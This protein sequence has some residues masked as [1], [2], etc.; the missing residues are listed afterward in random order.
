MLS[1]RPELR[2]QIDGVAIHPYAPTPDDVLH[3]VVTA[4]QAMNGLGL[5]K[6]PLYVTEIGWSTSPS[7]AGKYAPARLRP[8]YLETLF[9]T[10]GHTNCGIAATILY[11]WMTPERNPA[12]GNDWLGIHP[13]AGGDTPDVRAFTNGVRAARSPR[14]AV[15]ICG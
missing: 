13:P 2:G 7:A 14:R 4:R 3:G 11:A 1:A 12:E 8:G 10:L 6:V 5:A 9:T 15:N